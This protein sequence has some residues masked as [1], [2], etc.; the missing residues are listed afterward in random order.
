MDED[1]LLV[2]ARARLA[3]GA[4]F[5]PQGRNIEEGLDCVGLAALAFGAAEADVPRDY[6]LR[7]VPA[8]GLEQLLARHG[9]AR[10]GGEALRAGDLAV[11]E[12]GPGQVHL[13]IVVGTTLIH[14]DM[15][16]RRIVERPLPAPWPLTALWRQRMQRE[17][18]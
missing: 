3:L 14:A 4:R 9:L 6:P 17:Q 11:F 5:K 13:A 7:G 18:G 16:L 15:R 8:G 12:P 1:A 10:A 2:V